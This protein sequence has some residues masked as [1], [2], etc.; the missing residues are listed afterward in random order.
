LSICGWDPVHGMTGLRARLGL[1]LDFDT[2]LGGFGQR[3]PELTGWIG[4]DRE[5]AL[6]CCFDA[7]DDMS[8]V[9]LALAETDLPVL[10][11]D[12]HDDLHHDTA[13]ELAERLPTVT[14]LET[15]GDHAAA[16]LVH[17]DDALAGL[18]HFLA[19]STG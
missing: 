17:R 13:L 2:V 18:R 4:P 10:F 12:G 11:W 5:P 6:R 19:S 14:F 15:P 1:A 9:E 8:G 16:F 3:Y 7:L